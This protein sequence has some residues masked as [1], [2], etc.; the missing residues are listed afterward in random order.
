MSKQIA[1]NITE[2]KTMG[3]D[4]VK[5]MAIKHPYYCAGDNYYSN[6]ARTEWRNLTEFLDEF[7]S[8]DVDMNQVFRWDIREVENDDGKRMG[9]FYAEIFIIGQRK[10]IFMPHYIHVAHENEMPRL[11]AYLNK[12]WVNLQL[13]WEP[14]SKLPLKA[15]TEIAIGESDEN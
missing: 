5:L 8:A 7:E 4:A 15:I 3:V 1:K 10:G 11:I 2:N 12:H 9:Y 14:I 13:M 6:E